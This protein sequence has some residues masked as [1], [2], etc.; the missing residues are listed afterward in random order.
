MKQRSK[1]PSKVLAVYFLVAS[2][3]L[4]SVILDEFSRVINIY[5]LCLSV[6]GFILDSLGL[7][8]L[9]VPSYDNPKVAMSMKIASV[10]ETIV[11]LAYFLRVKK[12]LLLNLQDV[13]LLPSLKDNGLTVLWIVPVILAIIA[14]ALVRVMPYITAIVALNCVYES[15]V[16]DLDEKSN[17]AAKTE[18]STEFDAELNVCAPEK[19]EK[20]EKDAEGTSLRFEFAERLKDCLTDEEVFD[21]CLEFLTG[22]KY[23]YQ[24]IEQGAK[25]A[26]KSKKIKKSKKAKVVKNSEKIERTKTTEA[27]KLEL[28]R[29]IEDCERKIVCSKRYLVVQRCLVL[30]VVVQVVCFVAYFGS[31]A[32]VHGAVHIFSDI[33]LGVANALGVGFVM[34][35]FYMRSICQSLGVPTDENGLKELQKKQKK[36]RKALKVK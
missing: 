1:K 30:N 13:D 5:V 27:T 32:N 36:A 24:K 12:P 16:S 18:N 9:V 31:G 2:V 11:I 17:L 21:L 15:G 22:N 6:F 3:T 7:W 20:T 33:I 8:L 4:G 25:K 29:E 26:K 10:I 35:R 14:L 34:T 28:Q 23:S 19:D